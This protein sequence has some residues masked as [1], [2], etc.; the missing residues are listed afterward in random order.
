MKDLS[1]T[2]I[3]MEGV[4]PIVRAT[5]IEFGFVFIHPFQDG[6]GRIQR[7]LIHDFLSS[8]NFLP[9][10]MIIPVSAHMVNNLKLYYDALETYSKPIIQ[11]IKY[12]KDK[13]QKLIVLILLKL[14]DIMGSRI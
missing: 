5:A 13:K 10:G 1:N 2:A 14:K 4:N 8:E 3:R 11:I 9:A 6:N 12:T 7:F